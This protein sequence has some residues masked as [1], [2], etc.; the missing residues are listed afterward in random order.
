MVYGDVIYVMQF[1][2]FYK[3]PEPIEN[4][5]VTFPIA[6]PASFVKRKI[7][8]TFEFNTK[9][10]IAADFALLKQ[11]YDNSGKFLYKQ[12]IPVV[13]FDSISGV[14][15]KSVYKAWY[16]FNLVLGNQKLYYWSFKCFLK[17]MRIVMN[18]NLYNVLD[19]ICHNRLMKFL[20]QKQLKNNTFKL[21][22]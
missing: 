3:V 2:R 1:G 10:R 22:S 13:I 19:K 15:S 6:H 21:I 18:E 11:I 14:S 12:D 8:D 7:F 20:V 16:E 4:F 17:K 9:Y 5:S